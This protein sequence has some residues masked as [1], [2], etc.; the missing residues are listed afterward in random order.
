[1]IAS[2]QFQPPVVEEAS[3]A[4]M[5]PGSAHPRSAVTPSSTGPHRGTEAQFRAVVQSASDAIISADSH[6]SIIAWNPAA[7][8][9]F[10]YRSDE[11]L[12]HPFSTVIPER[13]QLILP[14][15]LARAADEELARWSGPLLQRTGRTA[16]G[17][18]FPVELTIASWSTEEGGFFTAIV[19]DVSEHTRA[20]ENLHTL[21][22]AVE[23]SPAAIVI[24]DP[25]GRIE[26]VNPRFTE[27]TGYSREEAKGRYPRIFEPGELPLAEF[28]RLWTTINGGGEWHGEFKNRRKNGEIFWESTSISPVVNGEGRITHFVTVNEDIS[29]RRRAEAHRVEI[30]RQLH[31]AQKLESIGRLAAGIAHEINTPTQYIGDNTR[32][33]RDAFP[34]LERAF[35]AYR[36]VLEAARTGPVPPE[37]VAAAEAA[38]QAAEVDYLLGE[39]PRALDQSLEGVGRVS[40]IVGAMKEF[41]HPGGV[42]KSPADLNKAIESTLTVCR[43]EWKYVADVVTEFDPALPPVPCRLGDFNQ[44]VLNLVINAAHAIG[45]KHGGDGGTKGVITVST[46]HDGDHAE[47]RIRDSGCG[48]PDHLQDNIFTPFFTTKGVGKGTGQGLAISRSVIVEQHGGT[49]DFEST[50]GVG[51]TFRIRLPLETPRPADHPDFP[52]P[53]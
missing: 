21:S 9:I 22:R 40:G 38:D 14:E 53:P 20:A 34:D 35:A 18:E 5:L 11:I 45:E 6:G 23:Q 29:E 17:R 39:I 44:V 3:A 12:G 42:E 27:V 49:I 37:L 10:G 31:Q 33:V 48:I 4:E 32:F 8:H 52:D 36:Q 7:E 51:T 25:R 50:A 41:S 19:R 26:Y 1:M 2:V 16:E 28:D 46:R 24:T 15:R 43:N 47:I 30:E 13:P